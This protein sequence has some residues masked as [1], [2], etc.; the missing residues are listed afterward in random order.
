MTTEYGEHGS[1]PGLVICA[2]SD[3]V[4]V[5]SGSDLAFRHAH[6]CCTGVPKAQPLAPASRMLKP[7]G[8][9]SG[10]AAGVAAAPLEALYVAAAALSR[11]HLLDMTWPVR[12]GLVHNWVGA[13]VAARWLL[14]VGWVPSRSGPTTCTSSCG[15]HAPL[16]QW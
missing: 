9:R 14:Y 16:L 10:G 15:A 11:T 4:R 13:Q 3:S 7:I 1:D 12:N 6:P 5:G 2:G 8:G